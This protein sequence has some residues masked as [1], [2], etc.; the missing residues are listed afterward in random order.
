M[1]YLVVGGFAE[2]VVDVGGLFS[3]NLRN[4]LCRIVREAPGDFRAI[5]GADTDEVAFIERAFDGDDPRRE[6]AAVFFHQGPNRAG[7][8]GNRAD[9]AGGTDPAATTGAL[10]GAGAE[11]R[12]QHL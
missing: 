8:D 9:R 4:Y 6:E 7:A 3:K 5:E 12:A 2:E 1:Y 10:L 11:E